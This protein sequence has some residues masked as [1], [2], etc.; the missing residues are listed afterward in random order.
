VQSPIKIKTEVAAFPFPG[1]QPRLQDAS[2]SHEN[3]LKR[4]RAPH[5]VFGNLAIACCPVN[6]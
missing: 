6:A 4:V 3:S 2:D 5:R 1:R